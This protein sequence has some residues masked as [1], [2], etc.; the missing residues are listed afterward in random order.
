MQVAGQGLWIIAPSVTL[1]QRRPQAGAPPPARSGSEEARPGHEQHEHRDLRRRGQPASPARPESNS[2]GLS[3][4]V[5]AV[6][7]DL[8]RPAAQLRLEVDGAGLAGMEVSQVVALRG[9]GRPALY[10]PAARAGLVS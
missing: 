4:S 7:C 3:R 5:T 9:P 10:T 1:R 2:A 8:A 6:R